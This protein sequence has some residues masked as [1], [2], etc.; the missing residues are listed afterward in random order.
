MAVFNQVL[1]GLNQAIIGIVSFAFAVQIVYLLLF[2][3]PARKIAPAQ[4][5]HKFAIV[6][7]AHN[8][9]GVL[10]VALKSLMHLRYPRSL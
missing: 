9:E 10:P 5:Q 4:K 2:F 6:V 7:S 3:L 1:N 8:E